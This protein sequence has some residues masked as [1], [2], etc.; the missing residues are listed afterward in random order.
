[1]GSEAAGVNPEAFVDASLMQDLE[2]QGGFQQ[3][4]LR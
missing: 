4:P 2:K 1:L 3:K